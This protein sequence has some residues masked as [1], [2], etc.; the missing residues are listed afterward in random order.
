[1]HFFLYSTSVSAARIWE[2]RCG[3]RQTHDRTARRHFSN[4][5]VTFFFTHQFS[6]ATKFHLYDR[7]FCPKRRP[8]GLLKKSEQIR[9]GHEKKRQRVF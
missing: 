8:Q 1:M 6:Y 2:E 5:L 7:N 4:G 9:A 3:D